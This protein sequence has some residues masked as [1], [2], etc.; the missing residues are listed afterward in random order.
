MSEE[1]VRTAGE[2]SE[3]RWVL[4]WAI[5]IVMLA[6][7][8]Y[9]FGLGITPPGY[10]FLGYAH[11][12]DDAAVYLSWMRQAAD[13]H[14]YI[15][16]LFTNE[17]HAA[18]AFNVLFLSMGLK[19]RLLHIPLTWMFH[20]TRVVLGVAL[21]LMIW[22]FAKLFLRD[23][24]QRRMLIPLVGLSSG[25]GWM[26]PN[27]R[28]PVS[29]VDMWQPEA[30]TFLSIYLN[31]LFLAGMLLMLGTLYFLVLAER[32]GKGRH[33][34]LAG[35]CLL[36]LGNIH[37]YDVL[38]VAVVWTGYVLLKGYAQQNV[39]RQVIG[40]TVLAAVIALPSVCYQIW[41]YRADEVF[42]A[43]AN[44]LTESPV[45]WSFFAGYG[46][47]LLGA[48]FG[49]VVSTRRTNVDPAQLGV[50]PEQ[51]G[52]VFWRRLAANPMLILIAWAILGFLLPYT[53]V[54]QQRKLV[55]GLHIPLCVLCAYVLPGIIDRVPRALRNL[56]LGAV[57]VLLAGSNIRF[58]AA[59]MSLLTE[60]KTPPNYAPFISDQQLSAM[61]YLRKH[62]GP[63]DTILAPPS[64]A[65]F[66]PGIAGKQVYYGHWSETPGYPEKIRA[67]FEFEQD[68]DVREELIKKSR[69]SYVVMDS[70]TDQLAEMSGLSNV[71]TPSG[72]PGVFVYKVE[73]RRRGR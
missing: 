16:N 57:L 60:A 37:T 71:H 6:S 7:L 64:F 49:A 39:S 48:A 11:N 32:T 53:P 29:S 62:A 44:T 17:P 15:R 34:V 65:L 51:E 35:V 22:Q 18:K 3:I 72:E 63:H 20:L 59:D 36:L 30:N 56:A 5:A 26:I 61:D 12:I 43:R 58:L 24:E 73:P 66:V 47:L 19:A 33:P 13:G 9:L 31:P 41:V 21:I 54:A 1:L 68:A 42:R 45:I 67:W 27:V 38:T 23:S 69:A 55:M 4:G 2:S 40:L 10:H 52:E 25:I 50:A 28:M 46:L 14:F 70:D 8:P